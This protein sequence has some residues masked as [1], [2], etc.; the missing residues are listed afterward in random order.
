MTIWKIDQ[1]HSHVGFKVKHMMVSMAKGEFKKF[2]ATVEASKD[3][4]SDAKITFEADVDSISTGH[5][6]RD[7]H[8]KSDDFFNAASFPKLKFVSKEMKKVDGENYKLTGDLTIRDKSLPVTLD[9][10][11]GG[12]TKNPFGLIVAG[13]EIHGKINRKDYG[14]KWSMATETGGIVL[15]D[16]IKIEITAEILKQVPAEAAHA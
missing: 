12:V 5:E 7:G 9:V 10:E 16:E 2:D 6:Q 13:F 14:L 8:L 11:F 3:D 15:G 4:F 1:G